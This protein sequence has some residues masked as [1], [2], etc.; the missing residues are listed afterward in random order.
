MDL[1]ALAALSPIHRPI[2]LTTPDTLLKIMGEGKLR[3]VQGKTK[4]ISFY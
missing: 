4:N 3:F 1:P 2:S